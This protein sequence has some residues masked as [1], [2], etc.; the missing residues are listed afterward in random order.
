M[1]KEK[2]RMHGFTV[3]RIRDIKETGGRLVEMSHDITGAQLVWA[4]NGE[5]NKLFSV[6]FR[7]LPEDNTGVFHILEHSVLCGSEKYPVKEP[8]VELLKTSMN[9]FLNAMT[10]PDKTLYPVS[11]RIEQDYLNLAGVYLDAVFRPAILENPNIFY[12]EGRHID[13]AGEEPVY[14]GVVLNEMKGAMSD[15]DQIADRGMCKLLYPDNCYGF[16]SGGDPDA[17]PDLTYDSFIE[18]YK[19]FYHPS[20]AYFY[21]DGDIPLDKTLSMIESY[22]EGY[23]KLENIP[24][25]VYQEPAVTETE[26]TY[27]AASDDDKPA[28]CFGRIIGDWKDR[29]N[30]FALSIVLEQISDSNESPLKRAVLSSGLAEDMEIYINDGIF[31]PYIT[32]LFRG[33]SGSSADEVSKNSDALMKIVSDVLE[34]YIKEGFPKRGLEASLNQIDFRFRQYPEP[35]AL[36]RANAAFAGWL[37]GGDPALHLSTDEAVANLRKMIDNGGY[38]KVTADLMADTSLY[39]RIILMPDTGHAAR[40][41]EKEA[42]RIKAEMDAMSEA[43]LADLE[44][45][46]RSLSEWQQT[47]DSEEALASIPQLDLKDI[48]PQP[49]LISTEEKDLDGVRMLYHELQTHGIVYISAYFPLT[50]LSFEELSAAA[51]VT[52]FFKDLPTEKY[53]VLDLQEEIRMHLGSLSFGLDILS[54]DGDRGECT[55]CLRARASVLKDKLGY[56]EDLMTEVLLHTVFGDKARM[57]ELLTQID[58]DA[59]R[60]AVSAGHKLSLYAARSHLSA[61]DA[62]AEAV[63]GWSFLQY[64]HKMAGASDEELDA[65]TA[66]AKDVIEKSVSR[67]NVLISVTSDECVL[68]ERLAATLPSAP[69]LPEKAHYESPLPERMGIRIP[70]PVSFAVEASDMDDAGCRMN[71]SM[72]VAANI[73]SLAYLWNEIRVQG[74]AYGAAMQAGRSGNLFCYTYRDPSPGRSLEKYKGI[75]DF[76]DSF[77]EQ[78]GDDISGFIISSIAN[79]EPLLSPAQKGRAADDFYLSGFTDENRIRF[80]KEMLGTT[81]DDLRA[82]KSALLH[83]AEKAC[84]C[85]AGPQPALETCGDLTIFDL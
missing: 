76:A 12:Q 2:D 58:D 54:E 80:R 83:M 55:P 50:Q 34:K 16:N 85:V 82:Q 39:S 43:E 5:E 30:M 47:A 65:F 57:R 48:S 52:E 36:Y 7:T 31:Q 41:A 37:Y 24:E 51:L 23:E 49:E 72:S 66:F 64:M 18:R 35:Q 78:A 13:T 70:A 3:T 60:S 56:A 44:E 61:K 21:L 69:L 75:P 1:I 71:G 79:T 45:L 63:N 33:V 4:D 15:V 53:G 81:A 42:A 84:V 22:L 32:M 77:A 46:N 26:L 6:G 19:R 10:Y 62:A 38:E 74:G 25:F 8:F 59:K 29:D 14:K 17:I 11:S 73:I 20:N 67:E 9:T 40:E 28:V 68:P 27:P